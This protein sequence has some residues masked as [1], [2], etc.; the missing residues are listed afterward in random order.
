MHSLCVSHAIKSVRSIWN[1][2]EFHLAAKISNIHKDKNI[3]LDYTWNKNYF[4]NFHTT[5]VHLVDPV[6]GLLM[7]YN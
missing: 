3:N 7:L 1:R 5:A 6:M 2:K 4:P